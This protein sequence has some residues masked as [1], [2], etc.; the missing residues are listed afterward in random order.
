MATRED[1]RVGSLEVLDPVAPIAAKTTPMAA[2]LRDLT[3]H[4]IGLWSN[5]KPGADVAL[6]EVA[7]L[8]ADKFKDVKF[9]RFHENHPHGMDVLER[10]A[11]AGC[12]AIIS[13]TAD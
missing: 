7:R 8:L 5:A 9:V 6:D 13:S 3:G 12:D 1:V 10:A 2:R 11:K 4:T